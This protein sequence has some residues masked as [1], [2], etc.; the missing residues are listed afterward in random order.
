MK[1]SARVSPLK[2]IADVQIGYP[3]RGRIE[4]DP[5][6]T[7]PVVQ[8]RNFDVDYNLGP[9]TILC[10]KDLAAADRYALRPGDVLYASKGERNFAYAVG[11]ELHGA[12]PASYFFVIRPR[13]ATLL[14]E[15]LAWYINQP[16]AR[17]FL[18]SQ[19][20][21]GTYMPVIPKSVFE[22]LPIHVPP[23]ET[24]KRIVA[25]DRL[26]RREKALTQQ[27]EVAQSKLISSVCVRAVEGHAPSGPKQVSTGP[28]PPAAMQM[29][30][31]ALSRSGAI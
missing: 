31:R 11:G 10:V 3:F 17:T 6:G 22:T 14:P 1:S 23:I 12:I 9:A 19:A 25:L 27:L 26:Q 30:G 21:R 7:I 28:N 13:T 29:E 16:A 4:F 24:Q 15:Y 5:A 18:R 20:Q 8:L 2:E